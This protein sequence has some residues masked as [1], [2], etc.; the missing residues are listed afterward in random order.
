MLSATEVAWLL[1]K[2][3]V[4]VGFC[5]APSHRQELQQNPPLD[6]RAFTDAVFRAEGLDPSMAERHLYRQ[7]YSLI[8]QAF[9]Q[10]GIVVPESPPNNR[11]RGP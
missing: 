11:S 5:L 4:D 6:P 1:D 8:S 10:R 3:C 9:S 7:V 2:L